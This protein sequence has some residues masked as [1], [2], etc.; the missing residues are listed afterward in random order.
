MTGPLI[1]V[2]TW[3]HVMPP[4][5]D[6]KTHKRLDESIFAADLGQVVRGA[7]HA[8]YQDPLRFFAGTF[9]STGL[10]ALLAD[11]LRELAG[12]GA[13]NRIIQI[14]TP[15]GGG[16]THTLLAL[17]HLV[18]SG[19]AVLTRPELKELLREA[20]LTEAPAARVATIVGTDPSVIQPQESPDGTRLHTLWGRI[21]HQLGGR[22]GYELVRG[23][24]ELRLAPGADALRAVLALGPALILM[25]ELVNYVVSAA[26][27][28]VGDTTLKDQ[29]IAFLQ[30]LTSAVAQ[31]PRAA[32]LLTIPGSQTELYGQAAQDLQQTLFNAAGQVA[33]IVG[34]VQTVRTPVQ[35]DDIYEVLRRRLLEQPADERARRERDAT[36]R[37]V[38]EA[39]V[40]MYNEI[41]N[42]VPQEAREPAY[43]ERMVRAYPFH[44]D[45][46][47]LLYERWGTLP[48]FQRTR[49]ALRILGMALA[50]LFA[51]NRSVP[52]VLPAHIDLAPG[53]LRNE[54]VRV[55]DNPTFHNVLDSDI[56]GAG[57]KTKGIDDGMGREHARFAPAVRAATT[58]FLWSHSGAA[59]E[60]KGATEAQIRVGTLEPG[61]QPAIVGNVLDEFRRR[62]WYLHED[63][64]TYRFDTRANLNRVI[65]QKEEGVAAAAA[66][67]AVEEQLASLVSGTA[68]RGRA[69]GVGPLGG[70]V[71]GAPADARTY[72]FPGE[73]QDVAD[74]A[75][76]GIVLLNP[77]D[78]APTGA[79]ADRLPPFVAQVLRRYGERPRQHGNAL[80]VLVPDSA[81]VAEADKAAK[82]LLA[83]RAANNDAQ[84]SLPEGQRRELKGLLEAA[85]RAFPQECAR[86]Y[87]TVV[88]PAGQEG[89]GLEAFDLGLRAYATGATLWDDAFAY[90]ATKERYLTSVAPL[91]LLSDRFGVWPRDATHVSTQRLWDS[92]VQFPHLPLLAGKQVLVAAIAR[93]AD[94]GLLGY[95]VGDEAGPPFARG[96]FGG[97]NA[98]LT[99]EIAPTAFAVTADY[100]R[101]NLVPVVGEVR[102]I[103]TDLLLDPAIWPQGSQRR[104]LPEIWNAVTNH[105]APRPIAGPEVLAAAVY[106][107]VAD[108][109]FSVAIDGGSAATAP[110]DLDAA[111]LAARVGVE[112][113]RRT[114]DR[115]P[116]VTRF[117]TI[118]ARNIEVTQLSKIVTGAIVPLAKGGAKVTLR[119]VI[120]ADAPGGIDPTV[121]DLTIKETFNQL[122]LTPDYRQ[123]G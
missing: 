107:G 71:V 83:L 79:A 25:D 117:L 32:F 16:K 92:F 105:Y 119:L 73:T 74:V 77:K 52:L 112:L 102:E 6:I 38:A 67:R 15:F 26:A 103:P 65:V 75:A 39:Y 36:A 108:R 120:D 43:V 18:T 2:P 95:A 23:A 82:R 34:R 115:V 69:R 123:E 49:G 68:P 99:V 76:V 66:R 116:K 10:S 31:T 89:G 28:P 8:D 104:G 27:V 113:A 80:V 57:A 70:M 21:A 84:L 93:G 106:R 20:G 114:D 87:R 44:P 81:L 1:N 50:G 14:E 122:G 85:E 109:R 63:D 91:L 30:Q 51:A 121:L 24:D 58:I 47:R 42:D 48:D 59:T 96:R 62:L 101:D 9:L 72:V 110:G 97:H 11:V 118:D 55:L 61:M 98:D 64:R 4:H 111:R 88:V 5:R 100:A 37:R 56:A 60:T 54:L 29:T 17:Y 40:R 7:A 86:V 90:L 35:G 33:E 22:E 13:G 94:E 53:D 12:T 19:N 41:P 3:W 46:V 78:H 45:V